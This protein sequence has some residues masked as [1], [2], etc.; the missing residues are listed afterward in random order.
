[1]YG[2]VNKAIR[3]MICTHHG[4]AA[5]ARVRRR[6]EVSHDDFEGMQPYP[7]D[8]THRLV[9]AASVELQQEPQAL[10]RAFGEFWVKY[11]AHE[12][13]GPL[14]DM[15][16]DSLPEFLQNLDDLH[17]RVGVTFPQLRP[18]SFDTE[19]CDSGAPGQGTMHLH[20]HSQ[21]QGLAPMVMGLVEGLGERFETPVQVQQLAD[22]QS[23][24]D[25]DVFEVRYARKPDGSGPGP[26]R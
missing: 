24:A 23:G 18:P 22:R 1:M 6:A 10:L 3:D 17:A 2:L 26:A 19:E 11:T 20:Y 9:M 4:E 12:G 7:D 21:R 15:A 5:W 8:L 13:Y 25:H 16:G 14:M